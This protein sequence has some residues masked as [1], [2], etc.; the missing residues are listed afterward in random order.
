M[1]NVLAI[2]PD[3]FRVREAQ[4]IPRRKPVIRFRFPTSRAVTAG[5]PIEE[6]PVVEIPYESAKPAFARYG[7]AKLFM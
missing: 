2:V 5:M 7:R 3:S 1:A 6:W 4:S